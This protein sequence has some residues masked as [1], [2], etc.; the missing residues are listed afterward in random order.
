MRR[1]DAAGGIFE[2]D[3]IYQRQEAD[4]TLA[5]SALRWIACRSDTVWLP[6]LLALGQ[7][8]NPLCN[9]RDAKQVGRSVPDRRS[10]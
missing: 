1:S 2:I 7:V 4:L 5:V 9:V 6:G 8:E 10:C 3:E